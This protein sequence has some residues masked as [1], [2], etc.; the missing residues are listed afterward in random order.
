L[1]SPAPRSLNQEGAGR[2]P[3]NRAGNSPGFSRVTS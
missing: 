1:L 2:I 3:W